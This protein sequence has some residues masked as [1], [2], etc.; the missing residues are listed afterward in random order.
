MKE[1]ESYNYEIMCL[2]SETE[3]VKKEELIQKIQDSVS[4][5]LEKK[6]LEKNKLVW[7]VEIENYL[8]FH[9]KSTPKQI[10]QIGNIIQQSLVQYLLIN[11][12]KEKKIKL[13]EIKA[14]GTISKNN[15][16]VKKFNPKNGLIEK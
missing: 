13:R 5:K 4:V 11:L 12:D 7:P 14:K 2:F 10:Q 16:N 1:Q 9:V 15:G 6:E 8:L 3:R